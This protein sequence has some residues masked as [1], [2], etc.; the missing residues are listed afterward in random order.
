MK[1]DESDTSNLGYPEE[2]GEDGHSF[3]EPN[4]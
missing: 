3:M 2:N 4:D 1:Y